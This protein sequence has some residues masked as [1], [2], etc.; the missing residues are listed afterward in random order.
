MEYTNTPATPDVLAPKQ[1][2]DITLGDLPEKDQLAARE[3]AA[4]I[5]VTNTVEV[6]QYGAA[7]QQKL[8]VFADNAL[9]SARALDT[10]SVGETLSG[11]VAQLQGFGPDGQEKRG[12]MS[13]F[14]RVSNQIATMKARYDKV[15]VSVDLV[16]DTLTDYRVDLLKDVAMFDHLYNENVE[17]YRQ[18][19]IYIVAGKEKIAAL[20]ATDLPAA[21]Q[22]AA[23]TGDPAD[24]QIASD[25]NAAIDRFE[26]KIYDLELTRQISIQMAPQIRLLQNNDSLMAD[27]IHSALVNTLPLWKSQMVLALG[28]ENSRAAIAAQQA[29]TDTTNRMLRQNAEALKQGTIQTAR[30]TERGL[31]DIETL[32]E[33]NQKLIESLSEVANIQREGR[34]QRAAAEVKLRQM[35]DQLKQKLL[36]LR[37]APAEAPMPT[38]EF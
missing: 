12:L 27:K 7:A 19:C 18:L 23:E 3:F 4:K 24:A 6:L 35:E 22:K 13:I 31:V 9:K 8:T 5:N 30:A 25:L 28:L 37:D 10:G 29:V 1:P 34:A 2:A 11:L 16:A 26:K 36:E 33:T 32:T 38:Q 20:H 21:R 17:Y 14:R 15:S